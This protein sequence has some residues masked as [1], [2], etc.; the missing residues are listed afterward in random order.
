[1]VICSSVTLT[2]SSKWSPFMSTAAWPEPLAAGRVSGLKLNTGITIGDSVSEKVKPLELQRLSK[3]MMYVK[4]AATLKVRKAVLFTPESSSPATQDRAPH[5]P[6]Y[7][8]TRLSVRAPN[9]V[10]MATV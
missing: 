4:P 10:L 1:M 7:T 8:C 2:T 6:R 9:A 5:P 3:A